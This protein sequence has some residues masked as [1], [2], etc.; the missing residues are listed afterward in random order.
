[1][2]PIA[3]RH[4]RPHGD[5]R[6]GRGLGLRLGFGLGDFG[7]RRIFGLRVGLGRGELVLQLGRRRRLDRLVDR[8]RRR[9]NA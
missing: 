4:F 6:L 9:W 3:R 7:E 1:L 5:L 2:Q 8:F